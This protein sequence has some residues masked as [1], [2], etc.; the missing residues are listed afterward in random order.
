MAGSPFLFLFL[1][2]ILF[3]ADIT[4]LFSSYVYLIFYSLVLLFPCQARSH[5]TSGSSLNSLSSFIFFTTS[6]LK[7]DVILLSIPLIH[8]LYLW[9]TTSSLN[10]LSSFIFFTR[11]TS[12]GYILLLQVLQDHSLIILIFLLGYY[13]LDI[14][15]F[16]IFS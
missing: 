11:R 8:N 5:E 6:E 14:F 9:S 4:L 15:S 10:S 7:A 1:I 3:W 12:F 13:L 16:I 2:L